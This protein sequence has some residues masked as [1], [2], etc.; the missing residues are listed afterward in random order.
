MPG[1]YCGRGQ[2]GN[3][4]RPYYVSESK[5]MTWMMAEADRLITPGDLLEQD[6]EGYDDSAERAAL[7]AL[8]GRVS[9]ALIDAGLADLD[10]KR[11][12]HGQRRQRVDAIPP[13]VDWEGWSVETIHDVLAAMW[14]YVQLDDRMQP[15]EAVWTVAEWR[16]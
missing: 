11:A 8:R 7:E 3:H 4:S 9:D 1:Y 5:L 10:A 16:A 2:R 13:R 14:E 12:A 15:V 6:A